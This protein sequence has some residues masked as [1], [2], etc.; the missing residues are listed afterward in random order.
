VLL[1]ALAL[2]GCLSRILPTVFA[3]EHSVLLVAPGDDGALLLLP[4]DAPAHTVFEDEVLSQ[5]LPGSL[6]AI[7]ENTC[8]AFLATNRMTPLV[9][10]L[11]N[12]P[13]VVLDS[14]RVGTLT[15]ITVLHGQVKAVIELAIGLGPGTAADPALARA[16]LVSGAAPALLHLAGL[17]PSAALGQADWLP[18]GTPTT[19]E[20]AFWEGWTVALQAEHARQR[21][22]IVAAARGEADSEV[23]RDLLRRYERTPSN[24]FRGQVLSV[25]EAWRTP[26]V[27]GTFLYRLLLTDGSYYPQQYML[28]MANYDSDQIPYAKVLLA[29]NRMSD[30]RNASARAF[31]AAYVETFPSEREAVLALAREV[32]GE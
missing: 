14:D 9:Q 29:I 5:A 2:V 12:R 25:D 7:F 6:I 20:L 16:R 24:G 23:Q 26:G 10:T 13:A 8:A 18:A 32:F 30:K 3:T 27:V 4:D 31:V 11:S 19:A 17:R 22:E 28:W 1:A 21:P 15:G